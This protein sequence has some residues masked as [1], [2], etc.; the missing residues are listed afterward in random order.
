MRSV[1]KTIHRYVRI[2]LQVMNIYDFI[3]SSP[4]FFFHLK[5]NPLSWISKPNR[6]EPC[7]IDFRAGIIGKASLYSY[8]YHVQCIDICR[9]YL[10]GYVSGK[11][12][13]ENWSY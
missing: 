5:Q 10:I 4:E 12:T 7:D 13:I 3:P 6:T 8:E 2:S 9:L 1:I 11:T